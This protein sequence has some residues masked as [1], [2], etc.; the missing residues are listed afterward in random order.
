MAKGGIVEMTE[1]TNKVAGADY[2]SLG[3]A[4]PECEAASTSDK[5]IKLSDLKGSWVVLYFYSKAFTS[6]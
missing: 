2:I 6:G 4:A 5:D 3:N 1:Q